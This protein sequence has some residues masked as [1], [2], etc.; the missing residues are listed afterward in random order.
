MDKPSI[1]LVEDNPDD[2][3][4]TVRAFNKSHIGNEITVAGDGEEAI[5][6]LDGTG[7]YSGRGTSTPPH[8][9]IL[10]LKLPK[11]DGL[12]VLRHIRA[13]EHTRFLP[14]I[15]LTSSDEQRDMIEGY[16]LG[17]NSY[18]QKPVDFAK[19]LQAIETLGLYWLV[20]NRI[21]RVQ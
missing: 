18:I 17:A 10:D 16:S 7:Q 8:L 2:V 13:Q 3:A 9:V 5:D 20:F 4:L 6:Y 19:F 15:I 21:P 12:D 14:V 11:V 1:L